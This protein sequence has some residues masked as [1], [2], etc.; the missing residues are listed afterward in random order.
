MM[1]FAVCEDNTSEAELLKEYIKKWSIIKKENIDIKIYKSAESFLFDY[2]E[3]ATTAVLLLDIEMP[4]MNGMELAKKIRQSDKSIQIIFV[5]GI[6]DYVFEGYSV[7]AVS[8]ILKPVKE[9]K[10]F[11][12]LDKAVENINDEEPY[13]I[14]NEEGSTSKVSLSDICYIESYG[15]FSF[16]H[17]ELKEIKCS[18]GIN[19]MEKELDDSRF[20]RVH[21]SYIISVPWI[22]SITKKEVIIEGGQSIP[23]ARGKWKDVNKA[24]LEYYR[25]VQ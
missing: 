14:V 16:I 25:G 8:Y 24:Y 3:K 19:Q 11:E 21:R 2:Q 22:E 4:G 9:D 10:L 12:C 5:T 23:I 17:T 13:I 20:F 18:T 7:S 6:S 1:Q 15:H